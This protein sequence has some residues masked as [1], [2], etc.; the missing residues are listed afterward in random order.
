[1]SRILSII[2]E[3]IS[4]LTFL[5]VILKVIH[6]LYQRYHKRMMNVDRTINKLNERMANTEEEIELV[7][8]YLE[9]HLDFIP[10]PNRWSNTND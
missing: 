1:M 2:V 3:V 5:G 6:S 7:E 10:K 9:K 8:L 4:L